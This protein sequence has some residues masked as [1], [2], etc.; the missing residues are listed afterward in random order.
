MPLLNELRD[1]I[2]R[3]AGPDP[4][5]PTTLPGLTVGVVDRTGVPRSGMSE[6]SVTI[7]A[8][9]AKRT[10]LNGP[11]YDYRA[12]QFLVV[13]IDLPL[14]GEV[15]QATPAE[16]FVALSLRLRPQTIAD[17]LL[18]TSI[19]GRAPAFSGLAVSDATPELLDSMVRLLRLLDRPED[20]P[21]LA[22]AYERE[23]IWR[24]LT[25][26][27][28]PIVRQIA[29]AD[30]SLAQMARVIAW[31][32]THY[33]ETLHLEHLAGLAGLSISSLQR[34]FRAATSMTPIQFQKQIRLQEARSLLL[35]GSRD[36]AQIGYQI[37][38][39]SPSQFSREYRRAF[40]QPPGRDAVHLRAMT[41]L[42]PV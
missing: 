4:A 7:I 16:P 15:L 26:E 22:A 5:T 14:T 23:V 32:R 42:E 11:P 21:V 10:V 19:R 38:Y 9:G 24:L 27:R 17:L 29:L 34:H 35:S 3:H 40:G 18:E 37:G 13:S 20:R 33:A 2:R 12:G 25:G 30:S 1:L 31:I 36:I 6:P 39:E 41:S 28:G 8:Q